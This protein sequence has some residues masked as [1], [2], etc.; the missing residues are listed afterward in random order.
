MT[1]ETLRL[2]ILDETEVVYIDQKESKEE[3]ALRY[4]VGARGPAY[5]SGTGKAILA[6]LEPR[7]QAGILNHLNLI[8]LTPK[9]IPGLTE[10]KAQ[11]DLTKAR[12][13]AIDDEEQVIG[14]RAVGAPILD[15]KGRPMAGVSITGPAH[16]L[17][18]ENL[19]SLG[20]DLM[21]SCRRI[22]G[23]AGE[24]AVAIDT[25]PK[26][27]SRERPDVRC[28]LPFSAFLGEAP[29]WSIRDH[30]LY[31]VDILAPAIHCLDIS[32]GENKTIQMPELIGS[33]VTSQNGG[34]LAATQFGFK[35][36][37][38][39]T[40]KLTPIVDPESH[41]PEN[42]FNDG[43]CDRAGRYWA[44]TVSLHAGTGIGSLYRLDK[45]GHVKQMDTGFGVS[46]GIGWSPDNKLMYLTD[47]KLRR[48]YVY[49][50]DLSTGEIENRRI[51]VT[52]P[53][54]GGMPGGLTVDR[55]GFIW[56]TNWD[57]WCV[58]RYDPDGAI[59]RIINLPVPRPTSCMFGGATLD[60][61]YITSAR[62]RLS[63][64]RLSE[65]PLSGSIFAVEAG[66]TGLPESA[67][68]GQANG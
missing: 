57:G 8:R 56:S 63:S 45:Y 51:L 50:F 4:A 37:D 17:E 1:G 53:D 29:H 48:I 30:I 12:G 54:G 42:R 28:V 59:E 62:I 55:E 64:Q 21:E 22:S 49:D 61:L 2:A 33:V 68:N 10:L 24:S 18:L 44:G 16:R 38:L 27:L 36:I 34:L 23:N 52:V 40:R 67:Y 43:K 19:H 7:K 46:N 25:G 5:C 32:S 41:L 65:A 60:I 26:P 15:S 9:T 13:Y 35:S 3:L 58:S 6:F 66:V 14:V 47:S 31:W 20:R 11:L 39:V